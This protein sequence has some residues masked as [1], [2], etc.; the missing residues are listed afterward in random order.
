MGRL[1]PAGTGMDSYCGVKIAGEDVPDEEPTP[2]VEVSLADSMSD[3]E[4]TARTFYA[5]GLSEVVPD[6]IPE[7]DLAE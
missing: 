2:E 5:G 6:S 4:D 7:P 3:S 1:I